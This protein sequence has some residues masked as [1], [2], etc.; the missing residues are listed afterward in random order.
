MNRYEF[1]ER[2]NLMLSPQKKNISMRKQAGC[3]AFWKKEI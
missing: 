1:T 2:I 3:I